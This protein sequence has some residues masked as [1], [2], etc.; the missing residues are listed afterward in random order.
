MTAAECKRYLPG[1][2]PGP[3]VVLITNLRTLRRVNGVSPDLCAIEVNYDTKRKVIEMRSPTEDKFTPIALEDLLKRQKSWTR[4]GLTKVPP[5]SSALNVRFFSLLPLVHPAPPSVVFNVAFAACGARKSPAAVIKSYIEN[6]AWEPE[7]LVN[8]LHNWHFMFYKPNH[9]RDELQY[10][11]KN[12]GRANTFL[13][14]HN[15]N[16]DQFATIVNMYVGKCKVES[17]GTRSVALVTFDNLPLEL[18][19]NG[20]KVNLGSRFWLANGEDPLLTFYG[21]K[22]DSVAHLANDGTAKSFSAHFL[23]KGFLHAYSLDLLVCDLHTRIASKLCALYDEVSDNAKGSEKPFFKEMKQ[24]ADKYEE[25]AALKRRS[26]QEIDGVYVPSCLHKAIATDD[27][28]TVNNEGRAAAAQ[29]LRAIEFE[30]GHTLYNTERIKEMWGKGGE[31]KK[32][33][34]AHFLSLLKPSRPSNMRPSCRSIALYDSQFSDAALK[35]LGRTR[36]C[37][38]KGDHGACC[39]ELGRSRLL[40]GPVTPFTVAVEYREQKETSIQ[41]RAHLI[42]SVE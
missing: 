6:K 29:Y 10:A 36:M 1:V 38:F 16:C 12:T 30:T 33:S 39:F 34:L 17:A 4:L 19:V 20:G 14:L 28:L 24:K 11:W 13:V 41:K 26:E 40:N 18:T 32:E 27:G 5:S 37:K 9:V 22:A 21:W 42:V 3:H 7:T 35:K 23:H 15:L 8:L 2:V 25:R 31:R